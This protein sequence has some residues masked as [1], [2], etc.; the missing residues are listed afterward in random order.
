MPERRSALVHCHK[1]GLYGATGAQGPAIEL[2]ELGPLSA[3]QVAAFD[4]EKAAEA[5][6]AAIGVAPP[7]QRNRVA[8]VGETSILWTGPA[9]WLVLE[10][11]K[12]DLQALLVAQCAIEI[13]AIT[14]LSHARTAIGIEGP[15]ARALLS[16]LSTLDFD[17]AAFPSG[18][19]AQ[20]QLGQI[21]ALIHCRA[22]NA[23]DVLVFRGFAVSCWEAIA[24][25]ALEFGYRVA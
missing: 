15:A 23:F 12:R 20:T 4:E 5:I 7:R 10:P 2:R 21:G 9:R 17:V 22:E 1:P 3:V 11:E 6:E 13:S 16:K 19:C 18:A 24:D 8:S 14:D 25:A